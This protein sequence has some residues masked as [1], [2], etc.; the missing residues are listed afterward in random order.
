MPVPTPPDLGQRHFEVWVKF[1]IQDAG[2][3]GF[4]GDGL[5]FWGPWGLGALW[6]GGL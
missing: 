3:Q 4:R 6:T 2:G 1:R 5:G